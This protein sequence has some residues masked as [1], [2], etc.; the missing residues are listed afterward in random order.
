MQK[1]GTIWSHFI[2]KHW[3]RW[4][5]RRALSQ[6]PQELTAKNLYI[7]PSLFGFICTAVW[8]TLFLCAINYQISPIFFF[9][10]LLAIAAMA[11]AWEAHFNLKGLAVHC[12]S[13]GDAFQGEAVTILLSLSGGRKYRYALEYTFAKQKTSNR[14]EKLSPDGTEITLTLPAKERGY[15]KLP[16]ITLYS[17]F[18]FG[19]FR[20]WGYIYFDTDYY[21]Y[22]ASVS[23]EFWPPSLADA[24]QE[25]LV[26]IS[27]DE[28]LYELKQVS[29]PWTQSSRIAWKI[30]ARGQGW[31]LK[32][33][34][35]SEG[36]YWLF[37]IEDLPTAHLEQNL[38]HLCYWVRTA[39]EK[40]YF[41]GLELKG[42]R[43]NLTHGPEHLTYC[44]RQLATY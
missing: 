21:I 26:K 19:L 40:G 2:A 43:T 32:S 20:V 9:T 6:N 1:A 28:E 7:L 14:L 37:R 23:P 11:S 16:R 18:P 4:V 44:L 8:I 31:Y 29:D 41:Y 34:V 42:K 10:F 36:N 3:S 5:R 35:S 13:V 30:A 27:G 39:E 24:G 33:M 15:F 17:Y 12:V 22:P 38:Q 25:S